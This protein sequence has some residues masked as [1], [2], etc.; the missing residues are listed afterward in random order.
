MATYEG[1]LLTYNNPGKYRP[2][3]VGGRSDCEEEAEPANSSRRLEMFL[4][5]VTG[6]VVAHERTNA[7]TL[8]KGDA[9]PF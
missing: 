1:R 4:R 7:T 9:E 6:L 2:Q 8:Q 3:L 5:W